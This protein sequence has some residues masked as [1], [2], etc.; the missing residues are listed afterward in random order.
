MI[1]SKR[2]GAAMSSNYRRTTGRVDPDSPFFSTGEEDRR[3]EWKPKRYSDVTVTLALVS[4]VLFVIFAIDLTFSMP[5]LAGASL[6]QAVLALKDMFPLLDVIVTFS[7]ALSIVFL[8][9]AFACE[10]YS[11][12]RIPPPQFRVKNYLTKALI[13]LGIISRDIRDYVDVL[14]VSPTPK[15]NKDTKCYSLK[16]KVNSIRFTPDK[17]EK[18]EDGLG[19]AFPLVQSANIEPDRNKRG[20]QI[21]WVINLWYTS[22]PYSRVLDKEAP[23]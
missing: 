6:T 10:M 1:P 3:L 15:F 5:M 20:D 18:M 14:W 17:V 16:F 8:A 11:R 9:L 22:D 7:L 13:D 21:G 19:Q 23:W 4:A 2:I 12:R